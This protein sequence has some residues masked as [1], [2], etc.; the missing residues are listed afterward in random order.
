M[1]ITHGYLVRLIFHSPTVTAITI[2][3]QLIHGLKTPHKIRL[4]NVTAARNKAII[5]SY[6]PIS[7][8]VSFVQDPYTSMGPKFTFLKRFKQVIFMSKSMVM[9]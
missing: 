9:S 4:V 8:W 3:K 1:F 2:A 5:K 6:F 7:V